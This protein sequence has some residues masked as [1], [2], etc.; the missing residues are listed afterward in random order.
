MPMAHGEGRYVTSDPGLEE[1]METWAALRYA[2]P[3]GRPAHCFPW[4]PNGSA[5]GMA[6][7]A[8]R[9]G[10]VLALMPHPERAQILAQVPE[11]LSGPWGDAR[12]RGGRTG[13]LS[14]DG[15]GLALFRALARCL[16]A[17]EGSRT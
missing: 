1:E 17:G 4:N 11:D 12:R 15:P 14:A 10:N 9:A 6:G 7:V 3:D 2:H 13:D 16:K 5:A 8:N